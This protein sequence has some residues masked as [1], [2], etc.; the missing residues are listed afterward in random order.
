MAVFSHRVLPASEQTHLCFGAHQ[1]RST[2]LFAQIIFPT[3][4]GKHDAMANTC[5]LGDAYFKA[6]LE[7][8]DVPRGGEHTTLVGR[9]LQILVQM[10]HYFIFFFLAMFS[11][12]LNPNQEKLPCLYLY[13]QDRQGGK[14]PSGFSISFPGLW[15]LDCIFNWL[16]HALLSLGRSRQHT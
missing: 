12:M 4:E 10:I 8:S 13:Q 6:W 15:Q 11:W 1:L 3:A 16:L 9:R 5:T 2:F 7:V 14:Q